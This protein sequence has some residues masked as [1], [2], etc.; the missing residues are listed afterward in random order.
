MKKKTK[1]S[2]KFEDAALQA[3]SLGNLRRSGISYK[4]NRGDAVVYGDEDAAG[5]VTAAHRVRDAQFP[6]YFL[7]WKTEME[8]KRFRIVLTAAKIAFFAEQHEDGTWFLA[9]R[10]DRPIHERLWPKAL[11]ARRMD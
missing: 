3:F 8:A 6:W 7:K 9:R 1:R 4:L 10:A 5:I 2:I 11:G